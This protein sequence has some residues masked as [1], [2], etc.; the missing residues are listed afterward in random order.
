MTLQ[1]N[2]NRSI[3]SQCTM[4]IIAILSDLNK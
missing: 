4:L 1:N 2:P 3:D